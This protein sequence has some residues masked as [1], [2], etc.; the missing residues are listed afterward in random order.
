M[1]VFQTTRFQPIRFIFEV[2]ILFSMTLVGL[3]AHMINIHCMFESKSL[4][5]TLSR[6]ELGGTEDLPI[7]ARVQAASVSPNDLFNNIIHSGNFVD[8]LCLPFL[9]IQIKKMFIISYLLSS[10]LGAEDTE[11]SRYHSYLKE[12]TM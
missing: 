1:L 8:T 6:R 10:V 2:L 9:P 7:W 5:K 4:I 11:I 3:L 12:L